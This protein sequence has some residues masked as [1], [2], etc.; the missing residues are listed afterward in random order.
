MHVGDEPDRVIKNREKICSNLGY[1]ID[2]M[3][4]MQEAHSSNIHIVTHSD[5]GRGA[6]EY[7]DG[8]EGVDGLLTLT[9]GV[10]LS[11]ITADCSVSIL[12]DPVKDILGVCHAG[13]KGIRD[14]IIENM[15]LSMEREFNSNRSDILCGIGPAI[16]CKC[17]D[18]KEEVASMFKNQFKKSVGIF[19]V[20]HGKTYFQLSKAIEYQMIAGGVAKKNIE[21]SNICTSCRPDEF[22]SYKKEN[23]ITGRTGVFAVLK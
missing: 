13:W 9:K 22:Y 15:L 11:S 21:D 19:D 2:D 6:K 14:N 18:L 16:C 5:R 10:V 7:L 23:M 1:A 17:Y 8:I 12:Y 20:R 3:V 4:F